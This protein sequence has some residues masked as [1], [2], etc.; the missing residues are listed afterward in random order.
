M[1]AKRQRTAA[2]PEKWGPGTRSR[3]TRTSMTHMYITWK[4]TYSTYASKME[5]TGKE[6]E[7]KGPGTRHG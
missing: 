4:E 3:S 1:A 6:P 7:R 5:Q 2:V